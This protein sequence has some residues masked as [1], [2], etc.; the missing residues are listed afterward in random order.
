MH[1]VPGLCMCPALGCFHLEER[2][3]FTSHQGAIHLLSHVSA[4]LKG[5]RT[6]EPT[7]QTRALVA[8]PDVMYLTSY[9]LME[10]WAISCTNNNHAPITACVHV[11]VVIPEVQL[12]MKRSC[13]EHE[14]NEFND[15]SW[16]VM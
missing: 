1:T 15:Q 6:L 16:L 7:L 11:C 9:L 3:W 13:A 14:T 4:G 5:D 10:I 8:I 12:L 2:V